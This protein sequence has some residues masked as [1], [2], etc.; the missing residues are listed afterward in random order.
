MLWDS[1]PTPSCQL[2]KN[3]K[4]EVQPKNRDFLQGSMIK[5]GTPTVNRLIYLA[6]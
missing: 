5:A 6:L 1:G 2:D 3:I 4:S